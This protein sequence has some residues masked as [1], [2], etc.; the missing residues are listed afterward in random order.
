M[1][2]RTIP[3]FDARFHVG[4][5]ARSLWAGAGALA[6]L[7]SGAGLAWAQAAPTSTPWEI[8]GT[9]LAA[10]PAEASGP[11]LR[12]DATQW[13]PPSSGGQWGLSL[14]MENTPPSRPAGIFAGLPEAAW[15]PSVGVHWRTALGGSVVLGVSAWTRIP[16]G[17]PTAADL[18]WQ[19]QHP[20]YATRVELQWKSSR[21]GP[22]IPEWG[23][24]GL[25]LQGDSR[26][27]L[28]SRH[29]GPMIYYRTRF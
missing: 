10:H 4:F 2:S 18:V 23:A 11:T 14:G 15:G 20:A 9:R 27:L 16:A 26:L 21:F 17:A 12:L 1:I 28:R 8:T 7:A 3:H 22:L 25:Q 6:L 24:I 13:L 29:G 19:D 5:C